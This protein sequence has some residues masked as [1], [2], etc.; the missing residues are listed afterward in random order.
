MRKLK[1]LSLKQLSEE[2]PLLPDYVKRTILGGDNYDCVYL[3]IASMTG[4]RSED[5][6]L[7]YANMLKEK[8]FNDSFKLS[9]NGVREEDL[10]ELCSYYKV[11]LG[12]GFGSSTYGSYGAYPNG[13]FL[14]AY[15]GH[16]YV[17]TGN[18]EQGY[19]LYDPQNNTGNLLTSDGQGHWSLTKLGSHDPDYGSFSGSF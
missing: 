12:G 8:G 14:V 17:A 6:Q 19:Y 16:A 15:E 10:A 3:S 11:E 2:L 5:I 18:G 1:K 7:T 13:K 4:I 9:F